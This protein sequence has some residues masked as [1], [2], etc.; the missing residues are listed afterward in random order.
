[1]SLGLKRG[2]VQL[3]PHD[4]QWDE[5]AIQTIKKLKSIL[6]DDAVDIQHIGSTAI[7]AIKAKPIIDIAVGVTDFEK[8]M[9][10]NEQLQKEGIFYRG[11]DVEDHRIRCRTASAM[12]AIAHDPS[13]RPIRTSITA[14][15]SI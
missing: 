7:P 1:M 9:S 6:G 3:E 4:K 2:T 15:R 13:M 12:R 14:D 10:Y 8:I 11:S 5:A